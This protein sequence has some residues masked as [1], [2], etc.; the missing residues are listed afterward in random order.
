MLI[1]VINVAKKDKVLLVFL[2]VQQHGLL[3]RTTEN[4]KLI[5][6]K[7][8]SASNRVCGDSQGSILGPFIFP[9]Y[10]NELPQAIDINISGEST[11][12]NVIH[13]VYSRFCCFNSTR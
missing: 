7:S 12:L 8:S 1:N 3:T 4:L 5:N 6:K 2:C 11:A 10:I 13:K 9:L